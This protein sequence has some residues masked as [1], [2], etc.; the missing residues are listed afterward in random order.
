MNPCN[1]PLSFLST[2]TP[3]RETSAPVAIAIAPSVLAPP[4]PL[5][6]PL[7]LHRI[8][9]NPGP[10]RAIKLLPLILELLRDRHLH[11]IVWHR[12][13]QDLA[14]ELQHRRDLAGR[15][16][17]VGAQHA[18]AHAALVV[19]A[20][21]GVVDLRLEGERRWLEGVFAREGEE[22]VEAAALRV[23]G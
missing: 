14:R 1:H 8:Q 18:E 16:P 9:L 11:R 4:P 22:E 12:L 19:V 20:D 15:L 6:G 10:R 7:L 3:R 13:G 17:L 21:V 23:G 2:A 5:T